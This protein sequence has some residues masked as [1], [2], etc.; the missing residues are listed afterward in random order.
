MQITWNVDLCFLSLSIKCEKM[1]YDA[2]DILIFLLN[3]RKVILKQKNTFY[4]LMN[5]W[6]KTSVMQTYILHILQCIFN[7]KLLRFIYIYK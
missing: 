3:K 5:T 4:A 6:N 2:T 1:E 7:L